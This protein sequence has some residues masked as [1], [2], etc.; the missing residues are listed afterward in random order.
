MDSCI[1]FDL[2]NTLIHA[3]NRR[4]RDANAVS[5]FGGKLW[6]H[7]RPHARELLR[8]TSIM[9]KIGIW[10][11]GVREYADE[12]VSIL[13]NASGLPPTAF[14]FVLCRDDATPYHNPTNGTV[15]VK[16]LNVVRRMTGNDNV[17][18]VDDNPIHT[19]I[20][21]NRGCVCLVSPYEYA[22]NDSSDCALLFLIIKMEVISRCRN[23]IHQPIPVYPRP[24][25]SEA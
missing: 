22:S 14:A 3:T 4:K 11:A 19:R 7:V 10:T 20:G 1:V 12:V 21:P 16:N 6:I 18:L 15:Y 5:I 2:D 13:L 24:V 8:C 25:F 9:S 23:Y 17:C